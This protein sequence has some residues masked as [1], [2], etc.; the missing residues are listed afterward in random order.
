MAVVR[1]GESAARDLSNR[2]LIT[3]I[4]G[5]A[6]LLAK[7]EIELAKAEIRADVKSELQTAKA[8][9]IAAVAALLGVNA[10]LVAVILALATAIP[11]WA[12]ALIVGG[13]I[14]GV[15]AVLGYIGWRRHVKNPLA[16]TRRTLR[17]DIQWLKERL[18]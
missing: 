5:K 9:G 7:K 11:G 6:R 15:A 12:A 3:E 4:T 2:A 13:V 8:L 14:L 17:K 16:S 18:A 10:L 1:N